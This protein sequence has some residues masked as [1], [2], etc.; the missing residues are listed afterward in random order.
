MSAPQIVID[1]VN[2]FK[3]NEHQ[4]TNPKI[5]DEENTKQE[6]INPFF[7]ALGWDVNNKQGFSPQY[8]EV[9]FEDNVKVGKKTKAP[10]YSFRLGGQRIFF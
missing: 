8:K 10:D 1:L 4:Y 7:E 9:V 2:K 5:F 3:E 6:F